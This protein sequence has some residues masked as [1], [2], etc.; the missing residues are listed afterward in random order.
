MDGSLLGKLQVLPFVVLRRSPCSFWRGLICLFVCGVEKFSI[1]VHGFQ[2]V[3]LSGMDVHLQGNFVSIQDTRATSVDISISTTSWKCTLQKAQILLSPPQSLGF[4]FVAAEIHMHVY[5][6]Y[7]YVCAIN[8]EEFR[9]KSEFL[10]IANSLM[11]SNPAQKE[12]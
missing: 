3:V 4:V 8:I 7:T 5:T 10:C 6:V 11:L 9:L 2:S 12:N 1:T